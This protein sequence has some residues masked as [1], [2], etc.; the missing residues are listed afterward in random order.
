MRR[1][2]LSQLGKV[3]DPI[4]KAALAEIEKASADNNGAF[5]NELAG[6]DT[7][8]DALALLQI[9][10]QLTGN[11]T[12]YVR[13]DGSDL[14]D[15]L[16]DDAAGAFLTNTKAVA[17]IKALDLNGF[18][19]TV[20]VR[21]GTYTSGINVGGQWHGIGAGT[22]EFIGDV[23]TP[24]NVT[25]NITGD[26]ISCSGFGAK[27]TVSGFKVI[28]TGRGVFSGDGAQLT[29]SGNMDFGACG[30]HMRAPRSVSYTHLPSPRD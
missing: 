4:A 17:A 24:S 8:A 1:V 23:T 20:N 19:V 28:A 30:V 13:T 7:L 11:R 27:L 2:T 25:L 26:A 3:N 15:G 9:R 14:N 10:E 12:Y 29:I 16:T 6:S 21:G 18:N 5:G 22:V